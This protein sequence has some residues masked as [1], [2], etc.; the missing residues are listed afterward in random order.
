MKTINFLLIGI[1]LSLGLVGI[2]EATYISVPPSGA[3][4]PSE[5]NIALGLV[6]GYSMVDKFGKN[7]D[8]DT[9]YED[10]WNAGGDHVLL[11]SASTMTVTSI[12]VD[13]S[14]DTGANTILISGL[15]GNYD[16][17]T[18]TVTLDSTTPP[19]TV[20]SFIW[21]N[22]VAVV[23]SGSGEVNAND[24]S[25]TATTGGST[26]A[27]IIA[28]EGQTQISLYMIP[29]GYVGYLTR[30][31]LT[32]DT[33]QIITGQLM[34]KPF[35]DS[36]NLKRQIIITEGLYDIDLTGSGEIPEKSLI[37]WRAIA[38]GQNNI[39]A[40]GFKLILKESP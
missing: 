29:N 40:S 38:S 7:T 34:V 31:F 20:N 2:A 13:T 28:G 35:E 25:I 10:I 11:T 9:S 3:V 15:D 27:Y 23:E 17:Q 14:G 33:S 22:R 1:V 18:E 4:T 5:T 24:I 39:V 36:W 21:I 16:I 26:Q 30:G 12:G 32:T 19:T 8:V 37:K 6:G